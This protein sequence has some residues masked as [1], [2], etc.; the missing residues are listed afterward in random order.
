MLLVNKFWQ[1]GVMHDSN[2]QRICNTQ[3]GMLKYPHKANLESISPERIEKIDCTLRAVITCKL[4][5]FTF[6]LKV[7][8][9]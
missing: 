5:D 3:I 7:R 8:G 6:A 2:L 1:C 9:G 4:R